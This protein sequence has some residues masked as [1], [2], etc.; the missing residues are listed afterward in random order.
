MKRFLFAFFLVMVFPGI[1]LAKDFSGKGSF[2]IKER[3]S[4]RTYSLII[5]E[6]R[7]Y[8]SINHARLD[9]LI[10]F[11]KE[12][13]YRYIRRL[14]DDHRLKLNTGKGQEAVVVKLE[15]SAKYDSLIAENKLYPHVLP[16]K[17]GQEALIVYCSLRLKIT[18][19]QEKNKEIY[20][21][22]R[23]PFKKESQ[24]MLID[25]SVFGIRK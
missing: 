17:D 12:I 18:W 24:E 25:D 23:D 15:E 9:G 10:F 13:K 7:D 14:N 19:T 20:L 22:L 5:L 4:A 2:G 21:E 1:C 16:G 3:L 6:R 11:P 8:D